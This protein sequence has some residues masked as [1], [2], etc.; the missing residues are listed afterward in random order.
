LNSKQ[1]LVE[2]EILDEDS[3]DEIFND[4]D[5]QS[6]LIES[7]KGEFKNI[8]MVSTIKTF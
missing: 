4:I 7:E 6:S 8:P 1:T 2:K 3:E 5:E